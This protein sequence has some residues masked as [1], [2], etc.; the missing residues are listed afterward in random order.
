M[1]QIIAK[2]TNLSY[3]LFGIF[4]PGVIFLLFLTWWY[5]CAADLA[6]LLTFNYMAPLR[7]EGVQAG[8][9][10]FPDEIKLGFV[11]YVAVAAY[12]LGHL[13]NWFGRIGSAKAS[14]EGKKFKQARENLSNCLKLKV[15]KPRESY[16]ESLQPILDEGYRFLRIPVASRNWTVFYL[17]AK[18]RISEDLSRSLVSTYQNKYTL[19][20]ALAVSAVIWFWLTFFLIGFAGLFSALGGIQSPHWVPLLISLGV[21]LLTIWGFSESYRFHWTNFGNSVIAET[22][23]LREKLREH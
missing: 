4:I 5:W 6:P 19:H 8:D 21:S 12:F 11:I 13:L 1:D 9:L 22:F 16:Y 15:P 3:E 7:F 14:A 10:V 17:V 20:R 18:S 23:M 2:L